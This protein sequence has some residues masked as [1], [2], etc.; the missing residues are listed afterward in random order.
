MTKQLRIEITEDGQVFIKTIGMNDDHC[1]EYVPLLEEI[2]DA[3]T[4]KSE[5]TEEYL[6][7]QH[8]LTDKLEIEEQEIIQE[9][10]D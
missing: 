1:L 6:R 3:E 9:E 2:L 8:R 7:A 5:F 4:I 10:R